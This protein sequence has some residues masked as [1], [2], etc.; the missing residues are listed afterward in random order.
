[1]NTIPIVVVVAAAILIV[2]G[3]SRRVTPVAIAGYL[4]LALAA[5]LELYIRSR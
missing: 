4:L 1:M 3:R 5:A 2:I